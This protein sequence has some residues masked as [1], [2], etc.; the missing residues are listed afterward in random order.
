MEVEHDDAGDELAVM[1]KLTAGYQLPIDA[2]PTFEALYDGLKA[3][4]ADL[5]EHIHLENNILF[6][7]SVELEAEMQRTAD[8]SPAGSF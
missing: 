5:H 1:R 8:R 2:C 3:M 7:R 4:E 6:P